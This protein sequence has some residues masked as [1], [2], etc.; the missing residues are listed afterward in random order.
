MPLLLIP[1]LFVAFVVIAIAMIALRNALGDD[2]PSWLRGTTMV[3]LLGF[4]FF[5]L[6]GLGVLALIVGAFTA[7]PVALGAGLVMLLLSV[8]VPLV[9][10]L[11][12]RPKL[13]RLQA[14]EAVKREAAYVE[15]QRRQ[16]LYEEQR[17]R[18]VAEA[19]ARAVEQRAMRDAGGSGAAARGLGPIYYEILGVDTDA[20]TA[21][22][23]A[24][25]RREIRLHHPDRG[26]EER[27][28]QLINEAWETLRDPAKRTRYDRDSGLR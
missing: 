27:R 14:A 23:E 12:Y 10:W 7:N 24:A 6:A 16:E 25:Y 13:R 8:V 5:V 4:V 26:G 11:V 19:Q 2:A 17:A 22:I 9:V 18:M 20:S 21:D 1:L 15:W 28:A 3:I